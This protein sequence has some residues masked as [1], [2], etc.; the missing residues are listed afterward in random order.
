[1][2]AQKN[3]K[4]KKMQTGSI[5][6]KTHYVSSAFKQSYLPVCH[7]YL[8]CTLGCAMHDSYSVPSRPI[9]VAEDIQNP[10]EEQVKSLA[11]VRGGEFLFF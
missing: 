11:P 7:L 1:M 10:E 6:Q 2:N 8:E 3:E 5:L 9:N 4:Q